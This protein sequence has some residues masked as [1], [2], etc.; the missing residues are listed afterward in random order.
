MDFS[1][2]RSNISNAA[3]VG[4]MV[5]KIS[6][7]DDESIVRVERLF[8]TNNG[9]APAGALAKYVPAAAGRT[10]ADAPMSVPAGA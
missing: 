3:A 8:G 7:M 5:G 2:V 1:N 9:T 6:D 10:S 4:D